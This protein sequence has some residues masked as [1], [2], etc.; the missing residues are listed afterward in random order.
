MQK[1]PAE[2]GSAKESETEIK[3]ERKRKRERE[4]KEIQRETMGESKSG[5]GIKN[6][7]LGIIMYTEQ[8]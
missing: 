4:R 2:Y 1:C 5:G 3:R 8:P 6:G 7:G